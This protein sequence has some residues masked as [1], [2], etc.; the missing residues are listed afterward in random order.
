MTKGKDISPRPSHWVI[1]KT[2]KQEEDS[3]WKEVLRATAGSLTEAHLMV[4]A[5]IGEA[6][7]DPPQG[8]AGINTRPHIDLCR[9][10]LAK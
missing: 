9:C 10:P 7:W 8:E 6:V 2:E 3:K 1:T 5:A 4:M